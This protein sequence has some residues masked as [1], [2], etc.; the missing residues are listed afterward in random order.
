MPADF[1]YEFC[2]LNATDT[3]S[4]RVP[5]TNFGAIDWRLV[6]RD[7]IIL[8]RLHRRGFGKLPIHILVPRITL[9]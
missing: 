3:V 4:G 7:F 9:E 2:C 8:K 1:P 6:I 5:E